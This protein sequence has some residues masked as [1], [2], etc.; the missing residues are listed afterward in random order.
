[1]A[2]KTEAPS[3]PVAPSNEAPGE[4]TDPTPN[5]D[6]PT[7][8][9]DSSV[10]QASA[11]TVEGIAA[12]LISEAPEPQPNAI[13]QAQDDRASKAESE[14]DDEGTAFDAAIHTGTKTASGAWRK[15]SGRKPNVSGGTANG[16]SSQAGA[17]R[18]KLNLPG[19]AGTGTEQVDAKI[20]NARAGG[21]TAANLLIMLSVGIGGAEW[22]PR[23]PP[24]IP[25]DEKAALEGAF[26][27][28]FQAKG[29][30]DLPPG[31]A[32]V[33]GLGMYALPRLAMPKTAER[34]KG[35]KNWVAEKYINWK[36]KRA[37]KAMA[38][39]FGPEPT[40]DIQRADADARA[41]YEV[42]RAGMV[43]Q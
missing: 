12:T 21:T 25:Y 22:L 16:Q 14:R 26:A 34:A 19:G 42:E 11:T 36:A 32:L 6:P 1:M 35:F 38:R 33:A 29:W 41:R 2:K 37:K 3:P 4:G 17:S 30:E 39:R 18:P 15:K 43:T 31:W 27:D 40:S 9:S 13:S 8:V 24:T 10:G 7:S 5:A 28:Y 23:A 20:V